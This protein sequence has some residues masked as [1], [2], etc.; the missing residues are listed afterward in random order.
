MNGADDPYG[1]ESLQVVQYNADTK[2]YTDIGD[3][4]T[5]FEGQTELP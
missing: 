2:T 5:T 4:I 3:L 1:L